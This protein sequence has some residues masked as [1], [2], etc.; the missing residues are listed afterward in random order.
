MLVRKTAIVF[1]TLGILGIA[2]A[3]FAQTPAEQEKEKTI[4]DRLDDL[5][6]TIFGGILPA[7]KTKPKNTATSKTKQSASRQAEG[8]GAA[9]RDGPSTTGHGRRA[10]SILAGPETDD[11]GSPMG[12]KTAGDDLGVM[13]D[14]SPPSVP[15]TAEGRQNPCGVRWPGQ[16]LF[17]ESDTAENVS[18]QR[19]V[20]PPPRMTDDRS[21]SADRQV[22]LPGVRSRRRGRCTSGCRCSASR[23]LG[24]TSPR[25]TAAAK[26]MRSRMTPAA[27]QGKSGA[28]KATDSE[29]ER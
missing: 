25:A 5:G 19:S 28:D 6:K 7:E 21:G 14:G 10:G 24:R 9:R 26:P 8:D 11:A 17:D 27:R 1:L 29:L 20:E 18:P 2:S 15:R 4:L 23:Y 16:S 12:G 22:E 13:P 3:A